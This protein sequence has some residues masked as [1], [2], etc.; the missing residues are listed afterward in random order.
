MQQFSENLKDNQAK[1]GIKRQYSFPESK[2]FS[3]ISIDF[4]DLPEYIVR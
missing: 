1:A 3:K 2:Y 4:D